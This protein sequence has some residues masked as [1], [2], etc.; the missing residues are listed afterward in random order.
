MKAIRTWRHRK[1]VL[2]TTCASRGSE[3]IYWVRPDS[4][5]FER[6]LFL[7][8]QADGTKVLVERYGSMTRKVPGAMERRNYRPPH[9]GKAQSQ[10]DR[11]LIAASGAVSAA[12]VCRCAARE[13]SITTGS[14]RTASDYVSLHPHARAA[15]TP[16]GRSPFSGTFPCRRVI[17]SRSYQTS[18]LLR[19]GV[20][21]RRLGSGSGASEYEELQK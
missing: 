17:C 2:E 20:M 16:T 8:L 19:Y 13:R 12:P 4:R 18:P 14:L 21:L 9:Y 5:R 15:G 3:E 10:C 7:G 1:L 11:E 6:L